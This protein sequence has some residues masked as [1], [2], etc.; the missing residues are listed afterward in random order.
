MSTF[1]FPQSRN[2]IFSCFAQQYRHIV[3]IESSKWSTYFLTMTQ[4]P[5]PTYHHLISISPGDIDHMGH[6]NNAVYLQ[7]VQ[8]AVVSYWEHGSTL[9]AREQ[10][11]WVALKHEISYRMPV[12]LNDHVEAQV[13]ATG[14][15]GSRASFTTLFKRG[16]DLATEVRSSWCCVDVTTRRPRRISPDIANIFLPQ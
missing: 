6:V 3:G 5:I 10:M 8:E 14:T 15:H 12:F 11:L 7:W 16:D 1:N 4:A 13:T 9:E 2:T